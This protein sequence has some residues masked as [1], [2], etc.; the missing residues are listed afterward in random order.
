MPTINNYT[1]SDVVFPVV[2]GTPVYDTQQT[3]TLVI[4]PNTG[5]TVNADDFYR[6]AGPVHPSLINHEF[7]Q[8]GNNV[9]LILTFDENYVMPSANIDIPFCIGGFAR[10]VKFFVEGNVTDETLSYA[11]FNSSYNQKSYYA[12]GVAGETVVLVEG[13]IVA[14]SGYYLPEGNGVVNVPN[15]NY[16]YT[17]TPILDLN[18]NVVQ[19][20]IVVSYT[21]P[22]YNFSAGP[23]IEDTIHTLSFGNLIFVEEQ[24]I[25]SYIVSNYSVSNFGQNLNIKIFGNPGAFVTL[26]MFDG[27]N[28][29]LLLDNFEMTT[30][31]TEVTTFIP[32]TTVDKLYEFTLS[33]DLSSLFDTATGQPSEF[34]VAQYT[35]AVANFTAIGTNLTGWGIEGRT[36]TAYS[37]PQ[38]NSYSSVVPFSWQIGSTTNQDLQITS[39]IVGSMFSNV[40]S[41]DKLVSG[42]F[43]NQTT[44]DLDSTTGLAVGML[45][46]TSEETFASR[47][48][49]NIVDANTIELN[50]PI[51]VINNSTLE[52]YTNNNT[53]ISFTDLNASLDSTNKIATV[54]GNIIVQKYGTGTVTFVLDLDSFLQE[55]TSLPSCVEYYINGR[56]LGGSIAY[57]DCDGLSQNEII[58]PY[59]T[60]SICAESGTVLTSGDVQATEIGLCTLI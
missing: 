23:N 17:A 48:I 29:S 49:S 4:T 56:I 2:E 36:Y 6:A 37:V 53:F 39:N 50:L 21:F 42:N 54:S 34:I 5:F 38:A 26:S 28:T 1:V 40:A 22:N 9:H 10:E 58:S 3:V 19:I 35:A 25:T 46:K 8:A 31:F 55:A 32:P 43:T 60:F 30:Y 14:D 59:E 20:D 18:G 27:T 11:E 57:I 45:V 12:E 52:F 16:S 33:G 13:S 44:I 24:V 41:V 7:V 51:T 15:S 47:T